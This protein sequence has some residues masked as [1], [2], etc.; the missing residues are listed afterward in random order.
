MRII[1]GKHKSRQLTTLEGQNTRPM[2]DRM[3]ESVF[4]TIGPYFENDIVLDLF[5]GSGALALE[6]ISRGCSFAYIVEKNYQAFKVI[7]N[8][9]KLLNEESNVRV[10]NS[11]YKVALN[12]FIND[13]KQFDIIFLDPPYRLNICE[14]L[15]NTILDNNLLNEKGIIVAQYVRGNFVPQENMYLKIIKNY[16]FATSELCIFQKK[17]SEQINNKSDNH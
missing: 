16:N 3:K 2:T 4:N 5:G 11:D 17:D 1:S 6:S 8:N 12:K 13:K 10:Y 7:T 14:E 15:I 9:V